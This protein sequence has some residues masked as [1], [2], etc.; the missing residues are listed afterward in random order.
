MKNPS[1]H[2]LPF[3]DNNFDRKKCMHHLLNGCCNL[4]HLCQTFFKVKYINRLLRYGNSTWEK[5]NPCST[6]SSNWRAHMLSTILAPTR[7][8]KATNIIIYSTRLRTATA[9]SIPLTL[10]VLY[11]KMDRIL[12]LIMDINEGLRIFR[13][14]I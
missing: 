13:P 11:L 5:L 3:L 7:S 14:F 9:S 1:M 2:P 8:Y 10:G 12:L 6:Y 4:L